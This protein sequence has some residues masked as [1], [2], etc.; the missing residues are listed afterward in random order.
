MADD[1]RAAK[2]HARDRKEQRRGR[3][4]RAFRWIEKDAAAAGISIVRQ[5]DHWLVTRGD[6]EVQW[7]PSSGK[8]QDGDCFP[9]WPELK[10][11]MQESTDD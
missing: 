7:W 9:T 2:E 4:A 1:F 5:D 3:F 11:H 8:T 10:A 6:Y